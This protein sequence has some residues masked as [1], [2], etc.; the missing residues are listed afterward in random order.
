MFGS[1]PGAG[2]PVTSRLRRIGRLARLGAETL[3]RT[4]VHKVRRFLAPRS[5][6]EQM[7]EE[8]QE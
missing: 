6:R 3:V 8:H 1:L 4:V 2:L 7:D 5:R